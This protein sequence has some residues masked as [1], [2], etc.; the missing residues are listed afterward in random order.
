[1]SRVENGS[2]GLEMAFLSLCPNIEQKVS[3]FGRVGVGLYLV[4]LVP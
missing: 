2:T 3:V 1:M 4:E